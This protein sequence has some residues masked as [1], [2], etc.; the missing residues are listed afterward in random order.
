M[1]VCARG[2][3]EGKAVMPGNTEAK[4]QSPEPQAGRW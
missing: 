3:I 4:S 2:L 1:C